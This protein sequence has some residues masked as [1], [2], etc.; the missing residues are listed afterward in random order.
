[1]QILCTKTQHLLRIIKYK[2]ICFAEHDAYVTIKYCRMEQIHTV[3]EVDVC[4]YV[5]INS[6]YSDS[7]SNASLKVP[8][9]QQCF[10]QHKQAATEGP[11]GKT[12]TLSSS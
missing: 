7:T 12:Y 8:K 9:P 5:C 4:M 3:Q 2:Y 11:L 10:S 1:M 6:I